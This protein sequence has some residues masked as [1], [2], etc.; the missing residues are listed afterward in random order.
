MNGGVS[1]GAGEDEVLLDI[2]LAMNVATGATVVVYDAPLGT[3]YEAMF[4]AMI[5][6]HVT[7]ISNSWTSC[8]DQLPPRPP[9]ASTL[10]ADRGGRRESRCS[11]LPATPPAPV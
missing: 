5:N 3:S 4:N 9:R 10:P 2:D 1:L 6:D 8:E 11:T 7:I